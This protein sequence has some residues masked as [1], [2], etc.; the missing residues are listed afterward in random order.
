M[1]TTNDVTGD[2]IT[3]KNVSQDYRDNYDKIFG[4]KKQEVF[5]AEEAEVCQNCGGCKC[6]DQTKL[7][8]HL[9]SLDGSD[10]RILKE[11]RDVGIHIVSMNDE[12]DLSYDH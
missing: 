2:R 7:E 3:T 8:Q 11:L 4:K 5:C 9:E 6:G 10:D 1:T 12:G